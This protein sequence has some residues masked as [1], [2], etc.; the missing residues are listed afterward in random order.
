VNILKRRKKRTVDL[1]KPW[2]AN[3]QLEKNRQMK[4]SCPECGGDVEAD[5]GCHTW[6]RNIQRA[7]GSFF[8]QWMSCMPCDSA[9]IWSCETRWMDEDELGDRVPCDWTWTEGLNPGNPRYAENETRNPGWYPD[10]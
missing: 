1:S 8:E 7:D 2:S 6:P 9:T 5:L 3:N 4:R 10:E